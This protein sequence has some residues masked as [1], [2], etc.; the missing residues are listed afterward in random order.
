MRK[1]LLPFV[2]FFASVLGAQVAPSPESFTAYVGQ[3]VELKV[4][5]QGTAPFTYVWYKGANVVTAATTDTLLFN[6]IQLADA[7]S[8]KVVLSNFAG[9]AESQTVALV[10]IQAVAPSNV[11][12]TI[13]ILP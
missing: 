13:T 8:Y 3:K 9:S 1:L 12:I 7:G 4:T 10:V 2:L 5:A 11:K 6:G